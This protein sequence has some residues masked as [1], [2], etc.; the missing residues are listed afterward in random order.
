M[1]GVFVHGVEMTAAKAELP[2]ISVAFEG[3]LI[4]SFRE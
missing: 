2:Q 3:G 4:C 1:T